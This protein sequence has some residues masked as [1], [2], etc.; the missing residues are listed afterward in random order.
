MSNVTVYLSLIFLHSSNF[1]V[2]KL[3]AHVYNVHLFLKFQFCLT[4]HCGGNVVYDLE[5]GVVTKF[6]RK[7]LE[8]YFMKIILKNGGQGKNWSQTKDEIGSHLSYGEGVRHPTTPI[9]M[10]SYPKIII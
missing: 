2:I 8:N 7:N 4:W 1:G 3:F 6:L 9:Q 5:N 10:D